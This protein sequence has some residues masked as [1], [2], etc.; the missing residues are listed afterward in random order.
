MLNLCLVLGKGFLFSDPICDTTRF[1]GV[2][3]MALE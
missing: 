3:V 2:E 1:E